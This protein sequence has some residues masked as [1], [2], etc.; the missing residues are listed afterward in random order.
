MPFQI[1][2]QN[3]Q[4]QNSAVILS[5]FYPASYYNKKNRISQPAKK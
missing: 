3:T 2:I 1:K 5:Y 4:P